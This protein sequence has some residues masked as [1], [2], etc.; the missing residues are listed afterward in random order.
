MFIQYNVYNI[1]HLIWFLF[2]LVKVSFV[3]LKHSFLLWKS[4]INIAIKCAWN[5]IFLKLY[6]ERFDL[7][8]MYFDEKQ[9]DWNNIQFV[10]F[11]FTRLW[12]DLEL[13]TLRQKWKIFLICSQP[14]TFSIQGG[15]HYVHSH[16]GYRPKVIYC[17]VKC[18][19][20]TGVDC[21]QINVF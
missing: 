3:F 16:N 6:Q 4:F 10:L 8:F 2:K 21:A 11:S 18:T 5:L 1:V 15:Y 17:T 12:K 9:W 20:S 7:S 14:G 13:S 19:V